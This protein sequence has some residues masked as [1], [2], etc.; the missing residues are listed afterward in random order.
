[1]NAVYGTIMHRA[2]VRVLDIGFGTAALTSKLYDGGNAIT[3]MD[4]SFEMLKT[5]QAKMPQAN[6]LMWDFTQGVPPKLRGETFDFIVSTYALHHL[7]DDAKVG[8]L[9]ELAGLL[10][11]EGTILIGDVCFPTR[12]DLL[13]CKEVCGDDWDAEEFYFVFSELQSEL[14]ASLR[15]VFHAFSFCAGIVEIRK[16]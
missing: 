4:F 12:N 13:A 14:C 2:P 11:P 7:P 1:M 9:M 6:L 3:G 15:L 10:A 5:A 16:R 8:F